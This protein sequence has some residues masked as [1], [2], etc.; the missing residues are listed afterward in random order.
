[1][2]TPDEALAV[3]ERTS[4]ATLE[5]RIGTLAGS[6]GAVRAADLATRA[7]L[8][9]PTEGRPLFAGLRDLGVPGEP[10]AR[11]WHAANMLREHRGDSHNAVLAAHGIGGTEAHVLTALDFGE[12]PQEFSRTHHLPAARLAAVVDGLRGRGLLTAD[13]GFTDA[14]RELKER[15]ESRTDDLAAAAYDV[16]T[17]EEFD[18]LLAELEP[19]AAAIRSAP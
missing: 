18:E 14:G 15:I 6:P 10:S 13:G 2:T 7:A 11:L 8:S 4:A 5:R 1:M 17:A 9:A 12:T 19:I 3:R 16:L